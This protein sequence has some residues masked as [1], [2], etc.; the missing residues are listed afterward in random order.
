MLAL[1]ADESVYARGQLSV[2][3][4]NREVASFWSELQVSDDLK[5][6]LAAHEVGADE[7]LRLSPA[8]AISITPASAGIDPGTVALIVAFAPSVN[9]ALKSAWDNVILPWIRR[10][11]GLDAIKDP[12]PKID[13]PK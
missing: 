12:L 5:A 6:R 7:L 8:E 9:H 4:L 10:R 11:R 1:P 3:E 13:T 2:A